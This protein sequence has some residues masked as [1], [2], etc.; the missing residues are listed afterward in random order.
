MPL[1]RED[2]GNVMIRSEAT[3]RTLPVVTWAAIF[4]ACS[5]WLYFAPLSSGRMRGVLRTEEGLTLLGLVALTASI[6]ITILALVYAV[7]ALA[8][9]P[10]L[11]N[12]GERLRVYIFPF[13][14]ILLSNIDKIEVRSSDVALFAK[15]GRKHKINTRLTKDAGEFFDNI[16]TALA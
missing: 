13:K 1:G 6:A 5:V 9:L 7:R 15:D 11:L 10:A 12:D 2:V 14:S 3:Y 16:K 8:G 4:L